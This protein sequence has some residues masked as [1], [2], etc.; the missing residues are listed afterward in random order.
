MSTITTKDGAQIYYN[1]R[2]SGTPVVFSHGGPLSGDAWESQML[3]MV[4]PHAPH[5]IRRAREEQIKAGLP[6]FIKS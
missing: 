1:D 5:G 4:Y 2:G 3:L 6:A